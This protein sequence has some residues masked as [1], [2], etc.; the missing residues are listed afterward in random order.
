M[1]C[2]LGF[3]T[4]TDICYLRLLMLH[5]HDSV[6]TFGF[7]GIKF[8]RKNSDRL[9]KKIQSVETKYRCYRI[10]PNDSRAIRFLR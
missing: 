8:E 9:I 4:L 1:K 6:T 2:V 5:S 3:E 10:L 7:A